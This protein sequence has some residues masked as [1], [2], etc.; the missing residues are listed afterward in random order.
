MKR[1]PDGRWAKSVTINGKRVFFYSTAASERQ[2]LKDIDNQLLSYSEE[3]HKSSHNFKLLS[4]KMLELQSLNITYNTIQSYTYSLK[5]F[6]VFEDLDIEHITPAMVQKLL[7]DM[8]K[9]QQYSFSAVSKAKIVFGLVLDYAIV[10][11][12]IQI[13]NF[14]RS[15]KIPKNAPKGKITAPPDATRKIII[16]NAD[17]VDFGM[18]PMMFLC[19]G[20]RRGEQAALR[21]KDIDFNKNEINVKDAVEFIVNQPHLKGR[22]KTDASID[23]VPILSIL[24]PYL[25]NMCK[26]L[27]PDDFLFGKEKPLTK[28]QIDKRL[29]KY[30]EIIGCK[31][32]GHQLRHSFAKMIYEAGIDVKT[33][34]RLLRHANF[35]TTMN[36]YT[37]FSKEKTDNAVDM[38]NSFTR[39][40]V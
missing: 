16:E 24:R 35:N 13:S 27:S 38:L 12:G 4:E 2:A 11:E 5:Y 39:N 25:E 30:C 23:T 34:Q 9:K 26:D 10:H 31:F 19:T 22:P 14:I 17:K 29:K 8:V 3:K 21:R 15:I 18:W 6:S 20:L 33:A 1:R 28:T 40:I 7:D 37:E 36:I 32:N